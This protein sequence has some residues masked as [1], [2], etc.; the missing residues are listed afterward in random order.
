MKL[1]KFDWKNIDWLSAKPSKE[2]IVVGVAAILVLVG[3]FYIGRWTAPGATSQTVLSGGT[4]TQSQGLF[5]GGVASNASE[6]IPLQP[7]GAGQCRT[8]APAGWR[9]TDAN[10]QGTAFTVASP[11]GNMTA[12][13]GAVGVNGGAAAGYYGEQFRTPENL[14]L[15]TVS[16]LTNERAQAADPE[17]SFGYYQVLS[18]AT[19]RHRGYVLLYKFAIPADPAGYG[20]ILRIAIGSASDSHSVAGAGSVAAATRCTST[21]VPPP[22]DMPR[23]TADSETHDTGKSGDD[24]VT[25]AGTYNAQLG[26]GWVHDSTGQNYNVDVTSDYHETGPDGP[27]FYKRNGNDLIKLTPG[28]SD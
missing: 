3:L 24:D 13:Y 27:G 19:A 25:M 22:A 23:P 8:F 17:Q 1:P 11:D 26:T 2:R 18:F 10:R 20:L 16:V 21:L 12:S 14:A 15:Y 5:G 28:L 7:L 9:V 4:P 6:P